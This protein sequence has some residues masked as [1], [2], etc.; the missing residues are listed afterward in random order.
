M[1]P[2]VMAHKYT[3]PRVVVLSFLFVLGTKLRMKLVV[4]GPRVV[5]VLSFLFVIQLLECRSLV[6]GSVLAFLVKVQ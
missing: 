3:G 2:V 6:R 5:V 4:M 1:K